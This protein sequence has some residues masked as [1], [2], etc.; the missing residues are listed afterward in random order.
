MTR[1]RCP[2][3]LRDVAPMRSGACTASRSQHGKV[4]RRSRA[5]AECV[6]P[7]AFVFPSILCRSRAGCTRKV[8]PHVESE[9]GLRLCKREAKAGVAKGVAIRMSQSLLVARG[10][11]RTWARRHLTVSSD[12]DEDSCRRSERATC[13]KRP[14]RDPRDSDPCWRTE[15]TSFQR[16]KRF[17][18]GPCRTIELPA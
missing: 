6:D 5:E 17:G 8:D 3:F 13:T 4:A 15:T 7:I 1:W 16:L 10:T 2:F 12:N 14:R 9:R 18:V 11:P